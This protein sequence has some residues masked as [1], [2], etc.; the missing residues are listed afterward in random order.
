MR[1]AATAALIAF[2]GLTAIPT[3]GQAAPA[4]PAAANDVTAAAPEF[5]LARGGC[6]RG[7]HPQRWRG[8]HGRWHVRCAPNR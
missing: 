3:S 6:G 2:F 8:R 5:M 4:A 1:A 7:L